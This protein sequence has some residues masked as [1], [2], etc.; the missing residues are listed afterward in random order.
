[1]CFCISASRTIFGSYT[2]L[3]I[4]STILL[5]DIMKQETFTFN[6]RYEL[7]I[8]SIGEYHKSISKQPDK[9]LI[10]RW[11]F[12]CFFF[13]YCRQWVLSIFRLGKGKRDILEIEMRLLITLP[14]LLMCCGKSC[15][16]WR[17][18]FEKSALFFP[19]R[20]EPSLLHTI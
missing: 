8:I 17:V 1:V 18:C 6:L 5:F 14:P 9:R 13:S 15:L 16:A 3:L 12:F 10:V 4:V 20:R 19:S 11:S 7:I 2:S